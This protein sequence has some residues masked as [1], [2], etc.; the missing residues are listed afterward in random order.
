MDGI[1]PL[2]FMLLLLSI[3]IGTI[4]SI[5]L[6]LLSRKRRFK[7]PIPLWVA[8]VNC[9]QLVIAALVAFI[10][11]STRIGLT[12]SLVLLVVLLVSVFLTVV[13]SNN[14]QLNSGVQ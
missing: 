11:K 8:T 10:S 9:I 2:L 4:T 6:A 14:S 13:V 12:P 5:V 1:I 3:C 7:S